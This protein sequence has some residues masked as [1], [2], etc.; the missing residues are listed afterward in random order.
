MDIGGWFFYVASALGVLCYAQSNKE[1]RHKYLWLAALAVGIGGLFKEYAFL[2]AFLIGFYV[3]YESWPSIG[4]FIKRIWLPALIVAVPTAILHIYTYAKYHY[5]YMDWLGANQAHYIYHS[6]IIE[7]IKTFG[8]LLNFLGLLAVIGLYYFFKD[9]NETGA[10]KRKNTKAFTICF[11]L[12]AALILFWPAITQR[13]TFVSV[14]ISIILASYLFR[15]FE[16]RW[17]LFLP[18]LAIYIW[19]AFY[20]DSF[21]L[22]FVNLPF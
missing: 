6:R 10:A 7:Y 11:F 21:I 18:I 5:T 9:K 15:K 2:G 13:I 19:A 20:M 3:A 12:S 4:R 14:P 8:S 16:R 17:Y 22:N 1:D